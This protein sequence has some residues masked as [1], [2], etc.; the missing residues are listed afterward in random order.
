ME[1]HIVLSGIIDGHLFDS[2]TFFK[3]QL[4][5]LSSSISLS[6][7]RRGKQYYVNVG[8]NRE[9]QRDSRYTEEEDEG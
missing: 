5:S 6:V 7:Q 1:P 8:L 9:C 2:E 4:K 3:S